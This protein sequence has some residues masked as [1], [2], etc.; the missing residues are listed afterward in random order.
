MTKSDKPRD[1]SRPGT[2]TPSSQ[3][4]RAADKKRKIKRGVETEGSM[5]DKKKSRLSPAQQAKIQNRSKTKA[6]S[7][8]DANT[9][10]NDGMMTPSE[11]TM[12][13][14]QNLPSNSSPLVSPRTL[15][16][17]FKEQA[18]K[19]VGPNSQVSK[20]TVKSPHLK[21]AEK[22]MKKPKLSKEPRPVSRSL[23][24]PPQQG[25]SQADILAMQRFPTTSSILL[26]NSGAHLRLHD[27][28]IV[29]VSSADASKTHHGTSQLSIATLKGQASISSKGIPASKDFSTNMRSA[30]SSSTQSKLLSGFSN[31]ADTPEAEN[32]NKVGEAS[33][34]G[35]MS[36]SEAAAKSSISR[37]FSAPGAPASTQLSPNDLKYLTDL[38]NKGQVTIA[39]APGYVDTPKQAESAQ[40]VPDSP[41]SAKIGIGTLTNLANLDGSPPRSGTRQ[42]PG[43]GLKLTPPKEPRNAE[44]LDAKDQNEVLQP[45][46]ADTTPTAA[47]ASTFVRKEINKGLSSTPVTITIPTYNT[48]NQGMAPIKA[49]SV[50]GSSN[51]SRVA[52]AGSSHPTAK[53]A[54]SKSAMELSQLMRKV[55]GPSL[56][57]TASA[58]RLSVASSSTSPAT[59][60]VTSRQIQ[61]TS[62]GVSSPQT[63]TLHIPNSAMLKDHKNLKSTGSEIKFIG[64]LNQKGRS[65]MTSP[66][67]FSVQSRSNP[68]S[69]KSQSPS[70]MFTS[71]SDP[72][73]PNPVKL[74]KE[75][76]KETESQPISKQPEVPNPVI[77]VSMSSPRQPAT[78]KNGNAGSKI[79]KPT[80]IQT[81]LIKSLTSVSFSA[82]Q[83]ESIANL[84]KSQNLMQG[85]ELKGTKDVP[86]LPA[87]VTSVS[88]V[89][90]AATNPAGSKVTQT[91]TINTGTKLQDTQLSAR[92]GIGSKAA[93]TLTTTANS[94]DLE[95]D[96]RTEKVTAVEDAS[97]GSIS[98]V[99]DN[100]VTT[101]VKKGS[102]G[103][104]EINGHNTVTR[105]AYDKEADIENVTQKNVES[106]GLV[107]TAKDGQ[108]KP[109]HNSGV[110]SGINKTDFNA[111][112][113]T[114]GKIA[115]ASRPLQSDDLCKAVNSSQIKKQK[116]LRETGSL[117]IETACDE[118]TGPT[119]AKRIT[120]RGMSGGDGKGSITNVQKTEE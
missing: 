5:I 53:I 104:N 43:S 115:G 45:L 35:A 75:K 36:L 72:P 15:A 82:K 97:R 76:D 59:L 42:S 85:Q 13:A 63:I 29:R 33:N 65:P 50:L 68:G 39:P 100:S 87:S 41:I 113:E 30:L 22:A 37:S 83:K 61:G 98:F 117:D 71:K 56:P 91:G 81:A 31:L 8:Q 40:L 103:Q 79:C 57:S 16:S 14:S 112:G 99:S 70:V 74:V 107:L 24:T 32:F 26:S 64:F 21:Y 44:K 96:K 12:A 111:S 23:S 78:P 51:A 38:F 25:I 17:K 34:T 108:M 88:N 114:P 95:G 10:V 60:T 62:R 9:G 55:S 69:P 1:N 52:V 47:H 58:S 102:D 116:R 94:R 2:P 19:D 73:S 18:I 77:S 20:L 3:L 11:L 109:E 48:T 80:T 90:S 28:R 49:G 7:S 120:R 27:G 119:V 105:K 92:I 93:T 4:L 67:H 84:L 101:I 89:K 110:Q 118:D 106:S 46:N 66:I 86:N 54:H 6:S